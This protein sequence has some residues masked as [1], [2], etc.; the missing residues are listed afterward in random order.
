M[1]E[2]SEKSTIIVIP[3]CRVTRN[4]AF[5]LK[6]KNEILHFVQNDKRQS[7]FQMSLFINIILLFRRIQYDFS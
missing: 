5:Q 1:F 3:N 7:I 6:I 4:L 2:T